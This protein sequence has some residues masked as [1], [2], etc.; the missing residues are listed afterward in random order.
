[1]IRADWL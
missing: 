1:M